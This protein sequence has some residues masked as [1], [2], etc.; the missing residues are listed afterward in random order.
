MSDQ[1]KSI[2]GYW[3]PIR[4]GFYAQSYRRRGRKREATV[5]RNLDENS[6]QHLYYSSSSARIICNFYGHRWIIQKTRSWWHPRS[7][8]LQNQNHQGWG[9][10]AQREEVISNQY[11]PGKALQ[12]RWNLS[13]A[14]QRGHS[15]THPPVWH[16]AGM[17]YPRHLKLK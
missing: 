3:T 7:S 6:Y 13:C 15:A 17:S 11:A 14:L 4:A 2:C 12:K 5:F 16:V 10:V 1:S 9:P 8:D